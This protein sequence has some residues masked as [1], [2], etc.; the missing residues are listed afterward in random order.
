M[1]NLREIGMLRIS[2]TEAMTSFELPRLETV[3]EKL[4][5]NR[6]VNLETISLP[7]LIEV[8]LSFGIGN[9]P[10]LRVLSLPSLTSVATTRV[11]QGEDDGGLYIN[12]N[13]LLESIDVPNLEFS[14]IVSITRN[15]SGSIQI[16]KL[17]TSNSIEIRS[18][19][20][21]TSLNLSSVQDINFI[22]MEAIPIEILDDL[23]VTLV[24]ITPSITGKYISIT[25]TGTPSDQNAANNAQTL[26]DNGNTVIIPNL[27][28]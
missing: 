11:T 10:K 9:N 14:W 21:I 12:N 8:K 18:N 19:S 24:N 1:P 22:Q 5:I 16:P 17:T 26:I 2:N 6:N 25:F 15:A 20:E 28:F 13:E 23:L 4:S 27:L 3:G 7:S